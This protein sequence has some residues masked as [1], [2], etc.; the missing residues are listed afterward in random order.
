MSSLPHADYRRDIDGLRAVAVLSVVIFHAFPQV[1]PGGFI[2]VDI[3]FV[4]SGYLISSIIFK[5]LEAK[6]FSFLDFYMRRVR[7]IFPTLV[8]MLL[9]IVFIA[10]VMFTPPE[11][12]NLSKHITAGA[13]FG[14]NF[15]LFKD[16]GY[17]DTNTEVKPLLHLWSLAIEEQFYFI[18]P[19]AMWVLWKINRFKLTF[20]TLTALLSFGLN[21][22]LVE[23]RPE[24][25]FYMPFTRFWELQIG[26]LLAYLTLFHPQI[27]TRISPSVQASLGFA[28]ILFGLFFINKQRMFPGFWALLPTFGAALLIN[29]GLESR[30]NRLILGAK[31]MVFVGLI[32]YPLYLWHWPLLSFTF[33][34]EHG[35]PLIIT[36]LVDVAAA[37]IFAYM[38]YRFIEKPLRFG[39]KGLAKSLSLSTIM[40]GFA[41]FGVIGF[42]NLG[43]PT[44]YEKPAVSGQNIQA[45]TARAL[46]PLPSELRYLSLYCSADKRDK[47]VNAILGDS[48][49]LHL[50]DG[51][52][53]VSTQGNRWALYANMGCP[54]MQGLRVEKDPSCV[55]FNK[56]AI[57]ALAENK[58]IQNVVISTYHYMSVFGSA[59]RL[60]DTDGTMPRVEMLTRGFGETV[61]MLIKGGKRVVFMLDN[62]Q[63]NKQPEFCVPRSFLWIG[64]KPYDKCEITRAQHYATIA[65]LYEAMKAIQ[66]RFPEML[67]VDPTDIFCEG[68]TCKMSDKNGWGL[69]SNTE[70]I[71]DYSSALTAKMI[72]KALGF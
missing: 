36:R 41:L 64:Q 26:C 39:G 47:A 18:W 57:K 34:L 33:I 25:T 30:L 69:Y 37:F 10:W 46:C 29:A 67:I 49:S 60:E 21:I 65:P 54:P 6:N 40:A 5:G 59:K 51:L 7:R 9:F 20:I 2:G 8:A 50:Y 42:L 16:I 14:S 27:L 53:A 12:Y 48:H 1:L 13:L 24:L 62:P 43:Y 4:I 71:S 72:Y 68:G 66:K 35:E 56:Y 55:E 23:L 15:M 17:F 32:S 38:S 19:L 11:L 3:F 61:E 44:R 63:V 58:D 52:V 70:H 22:Y 31:P 28:F 45:F